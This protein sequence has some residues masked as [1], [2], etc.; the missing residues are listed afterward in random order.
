VFDGV[1]LKL[2]DHPELRYDS[3]RS[4]WVEGTS[5]YTFL[6]KTSSVGSRKRLWPADYEIRFSS[7]VIDTALTLGVGVIRI[8]VKYSVRDVTTGTPQ[9]ILTFLAEN[10]STKDQQWSPG[11]EIVLFKPGA[12]G[13]TT[14][15]TTWGIVISKPA[16]STIV[17]RM[18]GNGDVLLIATR[19]PFASSDRFT[20]TTEASTVS[21]ERAASLMDQIYVVP[22]PYVGLSDIEPTNRLPGATRGERRIYFEHLPSQ[23]T[24]RIF[25]INGDLV[26]T[27]N[28]DAGVQNGREYWNLLNRD[29]F[30]VA[31]GVYIAHI[32]APGVGEKILKFA[33]IK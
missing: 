14:D 19:R 17:P 22:N 23:C 29:G 4:K 33:L 16:D 2:E 5:N 12:T 20:I 21:T 7:S 30:S 27:L 3:I 10:S 24:I 31:Y 1:S 25:T 26:Q 32:D 9:R 15:T 11:E 28:H 8:P 18:P 6:A 13:L